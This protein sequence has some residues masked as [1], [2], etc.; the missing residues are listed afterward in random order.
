MTF[1]FLRASAAFFC[2]LVLELAVVEDLAD[3]RL[4]VGRDFDN[5]KTLLVA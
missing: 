4:A 5:V 1:C 2:V 3:R